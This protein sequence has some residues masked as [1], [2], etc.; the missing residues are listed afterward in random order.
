M[1]N[2]WVRIK[3]R[4]HKGDIIVGVYYKLPDQEEQVDE[5]SY[6]QIRAPSCSQDL[7]LVGDF[8]HPDICWRGNAANEQQGI[9]SS[10]GSWNLLLSHPGDRGNNEDKHSARPYT[11]HQRGACWEC[12]VQRQPWLQ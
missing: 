2:L 4:T 12:E 11:H 6:T 1:W 9:G 8:N 5:S 3:E 7:V 10:E